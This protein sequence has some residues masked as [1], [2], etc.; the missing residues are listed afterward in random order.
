[1]EN[2]TERARDWWASAPAR[3][4]KQRGGVWQERAELEKGVREQAKVAKPMMGGLGAQ[5]AR[6]FERV[7]R[8]V[9]ASLEE[10]LADAS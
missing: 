3:L 8:S 6:V 9:G 5:D 4:R 7:M 2:Q 10:A 1:L